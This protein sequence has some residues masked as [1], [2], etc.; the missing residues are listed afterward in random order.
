MLRDEWWIIDGTAEYANGDIGDMN[1][2]AYVI[3]HMRHH[4]A[5]RL[6][7]EY[8]ERD[9]WSEVLNQ[10][11]DDNEYEHVKDMLKDYEITNEELRISYAGGDPRGYGINTLRWIRVVDNSFETYSLTQ[12]DRDSIISGIDGIDPDYEDTDEI[13]IYVVATGQYHAMTIGELAA[14]TDERPQSVAA[15]LAN[16]AASRWDFESAYGIRHPYYAHYH[17]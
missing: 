17:D 8:D 3:E 1:H 16:S 11:C 14:M 2:D 10:C 12:E 6:G 7:I 13:G 4:I 9:D 15:D 5:D